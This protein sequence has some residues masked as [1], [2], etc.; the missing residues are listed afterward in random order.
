MKMQQWDNM[1][2]T[3]LD[4]CVL[5]GG[6]YSFQGQLPQKKKKLFGTLSVVWSSTHSISKALLNISVV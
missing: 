1:G 4:V 6:N 5:K 3:G 2:E